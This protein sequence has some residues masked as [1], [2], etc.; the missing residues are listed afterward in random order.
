MG[1]PSEAFF[2]FHDLS[3]SRLARLRQSPRVGAGRVHPCDR[4]SVPSSKPPHTIR[5][6]SFRRWT[7]IILRQHMVA[8][9]RSHVM[10]VHIHY[11]G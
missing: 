3:L 6:A 7:L 1:L 8:C 4:P 11:L 10:L 2:P 5:P 9:L